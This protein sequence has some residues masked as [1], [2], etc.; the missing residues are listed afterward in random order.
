MSDRL[1]AA[2]MSNSKAQ[3]CRH[4]ASFEGIAGLASRIIELVWPSLIVLNSHSSAGGRGVDPPLGM[5][6][7][8]PATVLLAVPD[9][10]TDVVFI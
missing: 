10:A 6:G 7:V 8:R 9:S 2:C 5:A 4:A 1:S 3:A